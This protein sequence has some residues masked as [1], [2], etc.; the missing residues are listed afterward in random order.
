MSEERP[1]I[2]PPHD[3]GRVRRHANNR[4][5]G[6]S[7]GV[8]AIAIT[9]LVL[10]IDLPANL[11]SEEVS[12]FLWAALPQVLY[13]YLFSL[14]GSRWCRCWYFFRFTSSLTTVA[15]LGMVAPSTY[16]ATDR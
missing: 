11:P 13:W 12:S 3:P 5:I 15:A 2:T 8:F 6:F 4:I 7:D 10:T 9:L 16:F 14:R 1:Q